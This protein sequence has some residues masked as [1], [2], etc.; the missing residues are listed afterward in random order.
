MNEKIKIKRKEIFKIV[1][2]SIGIFL[3]IMGTLFIEWASIFK[4][5]YPTISVLIGMPLIFVGI[6]GIFYTIKKHNQ[7]ECSSCGKNYNVKEEEC[8]NCHYV[9]QI[10]ITTTLPKLGDE[11]ANK[12]VKNDYSVGIFVLLLILFFPAG[13]IYYIMKKEKR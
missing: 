6:Y 11:I 4:T 10:Q 2:L 9:N 13:I 8:P 3:I 5:L 7:I 12:S 1:G